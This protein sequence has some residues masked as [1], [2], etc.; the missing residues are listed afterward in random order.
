MLQS[1]AVQR[2]EQAEQPQHSRSCWSTHFDCVLF[3][4]ER[5]TK[6]YGAA[7]GTPRPAADD[8][9][10][11]AHATTRAAA[12]AQQPLPWIEWQF[13]TAQFVYRRHLSH[14]QF[15]KS[16][17]NREY[18]FSAGTKEGAKH[19]PGSGWERGRGGTGLCCWPPFGGAAPAPHPEQ[20]GEKVH[21]ENK[22]DRFS[23]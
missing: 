23:T 11:A 12:A 5:A 15:L 19:R 9:Q 10:P 7:R 4:R 8:Q 17:G 14:Q 3:Q 1:C 2:R 13:L 22:I 20:G 18:A 16:S 6:K 21:L